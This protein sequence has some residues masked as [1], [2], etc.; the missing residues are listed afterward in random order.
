MNKEYRS[1]QAMNFIDLAFQNSD[2]K[3]DPVVCTELEHESLVLTMQTL[4]PICPPS[5]SRL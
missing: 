4:Y 2:S 3:C 1:W 5:W